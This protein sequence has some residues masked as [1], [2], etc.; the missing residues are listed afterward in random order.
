MIRFEKISFDIDT[1]RAWAFHLSCGKHHI[2]NCLQDEWKVSAN[3][4]ELNPKTNDTDG[5][6]EF[7]PDHT[8]KLRCRK[9]YNKFNVNKRGDSFRF[10]SAFS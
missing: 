3:D 7:E 8:I 2:Y 1:N 5:I 6:N 10:L 4:S 9:T